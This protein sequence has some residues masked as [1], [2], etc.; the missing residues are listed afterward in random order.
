MAATVIDIDNRTHIRTACSVCGSL[1]DED[2]L[3]E[4]PR[5]AMHVCPKCD[6]ACPHVDKGTVRVLT[7]PTRKG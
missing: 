3:S 7:F 5:C 2:Y 1:H 4:C 6:C